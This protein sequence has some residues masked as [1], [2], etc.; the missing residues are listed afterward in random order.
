M[1]VLDRDIW[2]AIE[3]FFDKHQTME[4]NEGTIVDTTP[5]GAKVRLKGSTNVQDARIMKGALIDPGDYAILARPRGFGRWTVIGAFAYGER[6][7][8]P[9]NDVV[10]ATLLFAPDNIRAEDSIPGSIL[11]AWDAPVQT[12]VVFEVQTNTVPAEAGAATI[13]TTRGSY[14][15]IDSDE[16]RF[17]RVRCVSKAFQYS[18]W[19]TWLL[20]EP[21]PQ[22]NSS[23][24]ANFDDILTFYGEPISYDGNILTYTTS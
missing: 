7:G 13:L 6:A 8:T 1:A 15:I 10:E 16:E 20:A 23:S 12:D 2:D 11:V 17:V 21:A 24:S 14:A 19:T 5:S 3:V 18:T 9:G 4:L 22:P